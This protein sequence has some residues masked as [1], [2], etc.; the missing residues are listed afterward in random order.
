MKRV[1][2]R[3]FTIGAYEKEERWLNDMAARGLM[4]EDV[5]AFRYVFQ[6]GEPGS[7]VYRIELL[8]HLPWHPESERYL[9]FLEETGV[10]VVGS[11]A[12]W[13]YLRKRAGEGG[14][15]LFSDLDSRIRH[16]RRVMQI[17]NVLAIFFVVLTVGLL[18]EGWSQYVGYADWFRRGF[19]CRPYH[20]PYFVWGGAVA[21][22]AA[23]L[24]LIVLPVRKAMRRLKRERTI[25]E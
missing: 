5:C 16:Y 9:R 21:V 3:Y 7:C 18:W 1:V 24:Q 11:F 20:V 15:T 19:S 4:L 22:L 2:W 6:E 8:E 10:Q 14:F 25:R 23:F 17:A 13:V 12:R